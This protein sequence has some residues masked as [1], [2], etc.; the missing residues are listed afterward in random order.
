MKVAVILYTHFTGFKSSKEVWIIKIQFLDSTNYF[1]RES[2]SQEFGG[3]PSSFH[4]RYF[5]ERIHALFIL[6][7]KKC[8]YRQSS[9]IE[10]LNT[11]LALDCWE[12]MY[13]ANEVENQFFYV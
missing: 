2:C 3:Q 11:Q 10:F 8:L 9:Y 12:E 13:T 4:A 5:T 6:L 1:F 7:K